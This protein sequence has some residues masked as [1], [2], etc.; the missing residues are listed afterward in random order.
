[1]ETVLTRV[2]GA[3]DLVVGRRDSGWRKLD[4]SADGF[5]NSFLAIPVCVPALLVTW[6]AHGTILA[7]AGTRV[8]PAGLVLSLALIELL[9]W[10]AT[11]ALIALVARPLGWAE[12]VVPVV[13]A[14]NWASVPVAYARAVPS[15]LLLLVGMGE[16][17]AF[18]MLVVE[19]MIMVAYWRV[20]AAA[21][22]RPAVMTTLVFLAT[23][24]LGYALADWGHQAFGLLPPAA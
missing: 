4:L 1:M 7:E 13:I 15:A 11:L 24:V 12:R 6:L 8:T 14:L 9:I 2:D 10:F 18:V 3:L 22:D 16:G 17:I 20:L 21:L 23:F 5:W 19:V